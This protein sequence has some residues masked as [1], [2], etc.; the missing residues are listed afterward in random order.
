M[1]MRPGWVLCYEDEV[2]ERG[3]IYRTLKRKLLEEL[4]SKMME[5]YSLGKSKVRL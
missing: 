3:H 4:Q 5:A 1:T 2:Y